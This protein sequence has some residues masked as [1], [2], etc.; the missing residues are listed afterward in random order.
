MIWLLWSLTAL[1]AWL[2]YD[3]IHVHGI[4]APAF[5]PTDTG[6]PSHELTTK[7][8]VKRSGRLVAAVFMV[9]AGVCGATA[10]LMGP[11]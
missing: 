1:F 4:K 5:R 7:P 3:A 9:L 11:Q 10:L 2:A 8:I 6:V